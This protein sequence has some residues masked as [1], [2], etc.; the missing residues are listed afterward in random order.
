MKAFDYSNV[1]NHRTYDVLMPIA[2]V[3]SAAAAR[4]KC[5][6]AENIPKSGGFILACNHITAFDPI[7]I[8]SHFPLPIHFIGKEEL[9]ASAFVGWFLTKLN[10]F[11]VT[12]GSFD[13]SSVEYAIKLVKEGY[14]LGIFPEGT[15][16]KDFKPSR[17][18]SGVALIAKAARADVLP[19]SI[20]TS[21]NAKF[22][23]K[24]TIRF[25]KPIKFEELGFSDDGH[26]S[27]ELREASRLIMERIVELWEKGHE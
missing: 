27:K 22:G 5:V 17:A 14:V 2:R 7:H 26:S 10:A 24:L 25:G 21:D 20:Y 12:R 6:G 1:K 9:F 3:A 13:K 11:P 8:A 18:K 16:S 19:A 4:P 15:R 23:S